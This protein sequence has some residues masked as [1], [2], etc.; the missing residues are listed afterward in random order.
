MPTTPRFAN[1]QTSA[2]ALGLACDTTHIYYASMADAPNAC[3]SLWASLVSNNS[4]LYCTPWA[5]RTLAGRDGIKSIY[6]PLPGSSYTHLVAMTRTPELLLVTDPK[7]AGVTDTTERQMLLDAHTPGLFMRFTSLINAHSDTP[8]L[9]SW[10]ADLWDAAL[11]E[12]A[13]VPLET[14]G[15]CLAAWTI[16]LTYDWTALVARLLRQ[17]ILTL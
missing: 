14:F 3:K 16:E 7:A 17:A 10:A 8:V 2:H 9:I 5:P 4:K 11:A 15:D 6:Q 1:S 13:V 12:Y